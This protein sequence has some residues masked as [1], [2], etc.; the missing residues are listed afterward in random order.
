MN[1]PM[2]SIITVVYNGKC[3]IEKTILSVNSQTYKNYE[4]IIIDGNSSDNTT[5][6]LRKHNEKITY[7]ISEKDAGIYDAMNK[8]IKI[9]KGEWLLFMNCGDTFVNETTLASIMNSNIRNNIK[10]IYGD[11]LQ[12][13]GTD[14]YIRHT[15]SFEKGILNHQSVIYKK[16]L[17]HEHGM[18]IVTPKII[19]SDYLFFL[20][21]PAK[22]VLKIDLPIAIYDDNGISNHGNWSI[23]GKYSADLVFRRITLL[24]FISCYIKLKIKSIIPSS[25]KDKLKANYNGKI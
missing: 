6:I 1:K 22:E 21:I 9:A 2:I 8:G 12:K 18:Y 10:F 7:W 20:R 13:N 11:Y 14:K 19:V 15:T 23:I 25:L 16:E 4:Y 24:Q 3:H 5:E 17:H